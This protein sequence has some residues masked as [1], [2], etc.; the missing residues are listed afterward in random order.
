MIMDTLKRKKKIIQEGAFDKKIKKP[1]L[2]C[3]PGLVLT[4]V[5]TTG[6][7]TVLGPVVQR[8][9]SANPGFKLEVGF[10]LVCSKVFPRII[11]SILFRAS[12]HQDKGITDTKF[13]F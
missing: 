11:V 13:A 9:I 8:P 4:G 1:G 12:N 3:N 5:R 7:S 2:K 6:P 10:L